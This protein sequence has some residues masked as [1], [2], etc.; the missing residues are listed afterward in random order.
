LNDLAYC[1][2]LL[3]GDGVKSR[4]GGRCHTAANSDGSGYD[5][6]HQ[7]DDVADKYVHGRQ[8]VDRPIAPAARRVKLLIEV[9]Q[10][11]S[12]HPAVAANE[13]RQQKPA[14]Q[15]L[16]KPMCTS[17]FNTPNHVTKVKSKYTKAV[18]TT[19]RYDCDSTAIRL[20]LST[21]VQRPTLR[22]G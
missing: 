3:R 4:L 17:S 12:K 14:Q 21:T 8:D 20:H 9:G 19:T 18:V 2:R 11:D 22:S 15:K 16:R 10:P 13:P 7:N 5:N 1:V 6:G